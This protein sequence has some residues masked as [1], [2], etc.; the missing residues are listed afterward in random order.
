MGEA[1]FIRS[2]ERG[3]E[4]SDWVLVMLLTKMELKGP[5]QQVGEEDENFCLGYIQI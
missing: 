3:T 4:D 2:S 5:Q 1:A